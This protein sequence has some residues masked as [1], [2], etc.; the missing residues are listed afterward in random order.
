MSW[1][2]W[3]NTLL[4]IG[5]AAVVARAPMDVHVDVLGI[6]IPVFFGALFLVAASFYDGILGKFE[7][8][9]LL[10]F[11]GFYL[12]NIIKRT[13][14]SKDESEKREPGEY[15]DLPVAMVFIVLLVALGTLFLSGDWI[16]ASV[17]ETS[18]HFGFSSVKLATTVVAVGTS[19]PELITAI[20]L[21]LK[22]EHDTLFGEI[23]G[24]N[25]FDLV[26]IFGICAFITPMT[27]SGELLWFL[28]GSI[29]V[30]LFLLTAIV[31]D[32]K[33]GRVEGVLFLLLFVQF[34]NI[35]INL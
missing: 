13:R 12:H 28:V 27:M 29:L 8:G 25:I 18:E 2:L 14:A 34:N 1:V 5:A 17:L 33:V 3:S 6:K 24:S 19:I 4:G 21:V 10:I 16:V 9:M 11:M 23:I 30:G 31:T 15:A 20:I 22:N 7:G 26:G 32:R 35:L